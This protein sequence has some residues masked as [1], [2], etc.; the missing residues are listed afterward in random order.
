MAILFIEW[1]YWI[2]V[3]N[4]GS[5]EFSFRYFVF[6]VFIIWI[7]LGGCWIYRIGYG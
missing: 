5:N 1:E 7:R 4:G 2:R 6:E 3:D